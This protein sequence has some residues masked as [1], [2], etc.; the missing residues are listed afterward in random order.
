VSFQLIGD[1]DVRGLWDP[2][3]LSQVVSNLASNAVQ[4]GRPAAPIVVEVSASEKVATVTVTNA[5]RDQ[6]IEAERLR[7]LFDPYQRGRDGKNNAH[8]LG[9]GLYIVS[10]IVRAHHGTIAAESTRAGTV[11][12]VQLPRHAPG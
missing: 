8:G 2:D 6:P 9:L 3:R 4:Y 11:F 7:E 10:E 12:R 1:E 5:V